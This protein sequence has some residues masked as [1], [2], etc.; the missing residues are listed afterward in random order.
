[1][2]VAENL[3]GTELGRYRVERMLGA[4]GMG[5]VYA[6]V[7]VDLGRPVAIK[8]LRPELS[9]DAAIVKRFKREAE[10]AA[11]LSHPHIAQVTDFGVADGRAFLVMDLLE[12]EPLSG[13]LEREG[14]LA[15]ARVRRVALQILS[16]LEAAH[17]RGV[18]HRD[19]KP[20]NVFVQR[21]S[22][23]ELVKLLDFG[24]ARML[25]ADA[26]M[27]QTGAVLG[28]PA[29]MSP[30]QARGRDVDARSDVFSAGAVLYEALAGRRAFEGTNYH[31]LMFAVVEQTPPALD[32]LEPPVS[33]GFAAVIA[34]AMHKDPHAR[35]GDAGAMRAAVEALN[36]LSEEAPPS[37]V[38][39]DDAFAATMASD[40]AGEPADDGSH[41]DDTEKRGR[42]GAPGHAVDATGASASAD[43]AD[44]A[45][46]AGASADGTLDA[47]GAGASGA[48]ADG[49]LDAGSPRPPASDR[50]DAPRGHARTVPWD[51]AEGAAARSGTRPDGSRDP[52]I[53]APASS[54][55]G[56]RRWMT[57]AIPVVALVVGGAAVWAL[58]RGTEDESADASLVAAS[59]ASEGSADEP[60]MRPLEPGADDATEGGEAVTRSAERARDP[61][62]GASANEPTDVAPSGAG[63]GHGSSAGDLTSAEAGGASADE[64]ARAEDDRRARRA[65]R[66][67]RVTT[68]ACGASGTRRELILITRRLGF[69][70]AGLMPRGFRHTDA[71]AVRAL[72]GRVAPEITACFRGHYADTSVAVD[73]SVEEGGRVTDVSLY[74]YCPVDDGAVA[75]A[76]RAV[77]RTF[78]RLDGEGEGILRVNFSRV[79]R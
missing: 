78:T 56:G 52:V 60:P 10:L 76:E 13:V 47:T 66:R 73:L 40:P 67:P 38:R 26:K 16:A 34:R 12:G 18:V 9:Q 6:G 5:A 28:T 7:Q 21:A 35:F 43:G 4:G 33:P 74:Q 20:E 31:E 63:G 65:R 24:I 1:M 55:R 39:S 70:Y 19:L 3:E 72:A 14:R 59:P 36:G 54:P 32:A 62:D 50:G 61:G 41:G 68:V 51:E 2:D 44:D 71:P 45:T 29:Y 58:Q 46:G 77:A 30:E 79:A 53:E 37:G 64:D 42:S 69:R 8:V 15:E 27:T 75:C 17:A 48:S 23:M 22:G 57:Y 11:S 25:D 49:T